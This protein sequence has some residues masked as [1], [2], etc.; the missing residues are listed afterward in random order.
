MSITPGMLASVAAMFYDTDVRAVLSAI[1]VPT[2]VLRRRGDR[3]VNIRSGR[4]LADHIAVARLVEV[5]GIDHVPWF[6]HPELFLDEVEEF[7]TGTRTATPPERRH[8]SENSR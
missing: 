5:P 7:L 2:L 3:L 1:R 4:Y 8:R 6:E